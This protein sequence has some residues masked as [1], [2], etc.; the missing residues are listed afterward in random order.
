MIRIIT[1]CLIIMILANSCSVKKYIPDG[2]RIYRG[3]S[4]K[5]KKEPG[6]TASTRSLRNQLKASTRPRANKFLL[7]HPYKVW[8]W[9]V[10]GE[11]KRPK[12]LK[13]FLRN[14][15]GEPP[16]F[17]SRVN[18]PVT[19]ENMEAFLENVGYFHST[20]TGDTVNRSYFT[21]A[22]YD[23]DI[24]PQYKIK[25]VTWVSDSSE[26]L[27]AL[28]RRQRNTILKPGMPY[29][30]VDIEAERDRLDVSLKNRGFYYFNPDYI[31]AYADSTIGNHQVDLYLNVKKTTPENARHAYKINQVMIFPNYTLLKPPPD[32]SKIATLNIDGL[33]LRDTVYKFK[34]DLFKRTIIYRPG[35]IYSSRNQNTTLNRLINLGT[36]KFVKNRFDPVKDTV[37]PYR[38]NVYYYLTPA[39][40]KSIQAELDGFSK[41]N[42]Y[43]GTQLSINWR[44]RNTS[45][46]AELLIVKGYVGTELSPNDSLKRNNNFRIGGEA[47]INFPRFF[48]PFYRIKE[49]S[50][51]PPRTRALIGYEYFIKQSFYA[52]NVFRFQYDL[53]WKE[54]RSKEHTLAPISLTYLRASNVSDSFYKQ[55]LIDPTILLNVYDE[56]IIGSYYAYTYTTPG[57]FAKRQSYF[58][59]GIDLAGNILGAVTGAKK[60]REKEI[61]G[62]PFAQYA[63]LDF[64]VRYKILLK[65]KSEWANRLVLG[66]G[67]PYKNSNIL[68][69]SKQYAIGGSNSMR[70]F[71]V[72]TLGPGSYEPTNEDKKFFQI[73]G[74]DYKFL[75]NSEYRFVLSGPLNGAFFA[76]IGNIWTKDT[77]TFGKAGQLKKD[78]FKEIAVDAGFGLRYDI[79]LLI[80]RLDL[81]IPLRKPYLPDGE[82]WVLDEIK[83]GSR[84]WLR[85]NLILNIAI[86][87]PF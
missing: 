80:I 53:T 69:L 63:K 41:E 35:S 13:A 45:K 10:L 65:N 49:T 44:N 66:L 67:F 19:A 84:K 38:L 75:F 8:W 24:F 51:F 17:S 37:D 60:T 2:E 22:V 68:P 30:L 55:A 21:T 46:Q 54:S 3:S 56:A 77:I 34:P 29:R 28:T 82:R 33:L 6:V 1:Y 7:G 32:T 27:K 36:F 25:S 76:D 18:A 42:R 61:F 62:A 23:A 72:R 9:Y 43:F 20:V 15:L 86:G 58:N 64:D 31:M 87:Y 70:G 47:S 83:F 74:G 5:V 4:I 59:I 52:K 85:D 12:S 39:K 48:I 71:P 16:V 14:K 40:K 50:A 78:W 79:T 11:P 57:A 26:L 81:G 73:I